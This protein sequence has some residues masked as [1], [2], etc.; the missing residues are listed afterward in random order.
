MDDRISYFNRLNYR[1]WDIPL[2]L[3]TPPPGPARLHALEE[4]V[5]VLKALLLVVVPYLVALSLP[6]TTDLVPQGQFPSGSV[7]LLGPVAVGG[8]LFWAGVGFLAGRL[9][10]A[11]YFCALLALTLSALYM[12]PLIESVSIGAFLMLAAMGMLIGAAGMGG[13]R[14]RHA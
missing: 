11:A 2:R 3:P 14:F 5:F 13:S 8:L 9:W 10:W 1:D 4:T 7:P 6:A 12:L